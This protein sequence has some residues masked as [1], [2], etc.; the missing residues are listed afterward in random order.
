MESAAAAV[1]QSYLSWQ[2]VIIHIR[3]EWT[4]DSQVEACFHSHRRVISSLRQLSAKHT[5]R[6]K[7][8]EMLAIPL[9]PQPLH[10]KAVVLQME[11]L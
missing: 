6:S 4:H 10:V 8:A 7:A 3:L 11:G 5:L 1:A 9:V 2:N